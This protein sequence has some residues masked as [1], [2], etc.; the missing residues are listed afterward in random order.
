M[1]HTK[2]KVYFSHVKSSFIYI[3]YEEELYQFCDTLN[4]DMKNCIIFKTIKIL[5][6]F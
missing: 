1:A 4:N 5:Y 6:L 2:L 3:S